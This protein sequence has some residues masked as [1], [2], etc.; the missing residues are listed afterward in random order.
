MRVETHR[1]GSGNE[2]SARCF[3]RLTRRS[4]GEEES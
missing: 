4:D 1:T 3:F 2:E